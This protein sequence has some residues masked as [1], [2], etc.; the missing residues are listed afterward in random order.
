MGC[1]ELLIVRDGIFWLRNV[2]I[3]A[4]TFCKRVVLLMLRNSVFRV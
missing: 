4:V 1:A 2:Q 3:R